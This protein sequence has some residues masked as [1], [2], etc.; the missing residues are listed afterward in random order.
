MDHYLCNKCGE[1][2]RRDDL[3]ERREW[4]PEGRCHEVSTFCPNCDGDDLSDAYLCDGC[5]EYAELV[6]PYDLCKPCTISAEAEDAA[7]EDKADERR[8]EGRAF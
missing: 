5:E 6:D 1:I 2:S 7:A 4:V 3:T 8:Q